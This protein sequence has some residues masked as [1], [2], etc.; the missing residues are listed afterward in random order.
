MTTYDLWM[1]LV[2]LLRIRATSAQA[3]MGGWCTMVRW[4]RVRMTRTHSS[5]YLAVTARI[6]TLFT[7]THDRITMMIS[8]VFYGRKQ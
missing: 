8:R 4:H 1:D 2:T 7:V 6:Q 5:Y 3:S